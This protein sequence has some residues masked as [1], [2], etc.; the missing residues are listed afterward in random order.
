MTLYNVSSGLF[1]QD[2]MVIVRRTFHTSGSPPGEL[3]G[4]DNI[5]ACG[6]ETDPVSHGTT[7]FHSLDA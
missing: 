1:P 7:A 4:L 3:S 5:T 6:L 2:R